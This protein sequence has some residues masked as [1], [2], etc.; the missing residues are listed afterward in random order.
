MSCKP[1]GMC[2]DTFAMHECVQ[3]VI[4]LCA[5]VSPGNREKIV[6]RWNMP[7]QLFFFLMKDPSSLSTPCNVCHV[8]HAVS[9]PSDLL[10]FFGQIKVWCN[11]P[12]VPSDTTSFWSHQSC[13]MMT[14]GTAAELPKFISCLT[15]V[16]PDCLENH[17]HL[18]RES[19]CLL[20]SSREWQLYLNFNK[21][22]LSS[23]RCLWNVCN[24]T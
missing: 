22:L 13:F 7:C 9:E 19:L 21:G 4:S 5:L 23:M 6:V 17:N 10:T 15:T 11:F 3:I 1:R 20:E 24:S 18:W 8:L 2:S 16:D 12:W 14:G